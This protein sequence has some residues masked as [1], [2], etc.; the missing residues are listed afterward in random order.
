MSDPKEGTRKHNE[1]LIQPPCKHKEDYER[2]LGGE[3]EETSEARTRHEEETQG[4]ALSHDLISLLSLFLLPIFPRTRD[5]GLPF[6]CTYME[7]GMTSLSLST[8]QPPG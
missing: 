3:E 4:D 1:L 7:H 2:P 8:S 5:R 6:L